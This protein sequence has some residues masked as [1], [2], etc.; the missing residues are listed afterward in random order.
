MDS[1]KKL[2]K[3]F[4]YA[5]RGIIRTVKSERNLRIHITCLIYM[6]SILGLTDWFT[7][8]RTD[9]AILVV[10]SGTVIAAEIINTAIENAVNLA[11]EAYN[12]FA[13]ISKDAAAGAVLINA[14]FA[15]I[16]GIIILFQPKAFKAMYEYFAGNPMMFILFILSIVPATVFIFFGFNI[17]KRNKHE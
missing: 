6:F 12:K 17:G 1:Y 16:T 7:L 2:F 10:T 15:V 14:V 8:T 3:S 4:V 5:F 9:W 13:E 11:S